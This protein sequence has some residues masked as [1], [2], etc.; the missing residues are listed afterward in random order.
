VSVRLVNPDTLPK[1]VGYAHAA[2]G[3]G[4]AIVLA[5]QVGCDASGRIEAP[6][7]LVAQFGK[8][9]DN[10]VEALRAA[11]GQPSDVAR[12]RIFTTDV[13]G[14]RAQLKELG[15]AYRERMGRH[16]PAMVLAGVT[17]L[18]DPEARVEIEG[19]AYVD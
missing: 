10:L 6:D 1:P 16:F 7:D 15:A 14:Y 9:L 11:G 13:G 17:E 2:V 18:F 8:A 5:G 12:L 19:I 3:S 4:R